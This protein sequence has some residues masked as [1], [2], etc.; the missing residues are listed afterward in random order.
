[1]RR[2]TSFQVGRAK[3]ADEPAA[4]MASSFSLMSSL[5]L[6]CFLV[7]SFLSR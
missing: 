2:M 7:D 4:D 6:S 3:G 1:M 5:N